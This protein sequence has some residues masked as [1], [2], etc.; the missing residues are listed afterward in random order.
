[1]ARIAGVDLPDN[2]RVEIALTYIYGVGV[3]TSNK[4]LLQANVKP[5]IRVNELKAAEVKRIANVL[6]GMVLEGELKQTVFRNIKRLKD[7][8]TY[9]GVRHKLG[10]PVRGQRTRTNAITRKGKNIAVGGLKRKIEKT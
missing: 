10:L 9:R 3:P 7:I 6:S 1:M 5:D 4:V 2:K 8:R